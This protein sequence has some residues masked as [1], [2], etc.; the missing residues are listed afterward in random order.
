MDHH[1]PFKQFSWN[2]NVASVPFHVGC[3]YVKQ[4]HR[5]VWATLTAVHKCDMISIDQ[6]LEWLLTGSF[7]SLQMSTGMALGKIN[8]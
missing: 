1:K 2:L 5:S 7:S 6:P 3:V 8:K 4:P